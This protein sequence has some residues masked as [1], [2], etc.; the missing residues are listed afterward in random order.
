MS[1]PVKAVALII[2]ILLGVFLLGRGYLSTRAPM[3]CESI[4]DAELF[5]LLGNDI[6]LA[7]VEAWVS[8]QYGLDR[9]AIDIVPDEGFTSVTWAEDG[10]SYSANWQS[11]K[12]RSVWVYQTSWFA[13]RPTQSDI[14]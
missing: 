12:V 4:V 3:D 11:S 10:R 2:T 1:K 6:T 7:S 5:D 14:T 13:R 9:Q 8:Q